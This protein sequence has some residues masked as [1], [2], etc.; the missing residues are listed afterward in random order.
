MPRN[1]RNENRYVPI[2]RPMM[3]KWI[4]KLGNQQFMNKGL[5]PRGTQKEEPWREVAKKLST[6]Q[7]GISSLGK[8][9][10]GKGSQKLRLKKRWEALKEEWPKVSSLGT[11]RNEKSAGDFWG[12]STKRRKLWEIMKGPTHQCCWHNIGSDPGEQIGGISGTPGLGDDTI[13]GGSSQQWRA[14]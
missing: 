7:E 2:N 5:V 1:I 12:R 4:N 9:D 6:W 11:P 8:N 13:K 10:K 14:F 3:H